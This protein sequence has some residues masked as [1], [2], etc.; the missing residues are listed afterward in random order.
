MDK[1]RDA[2]G[3]AGGNATSHQPVLSIIILY[4]HCQFVERFI[5]QGPHRTL[6]LTS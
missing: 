4:V 5:I 6:N 1:V 2:G 3:V